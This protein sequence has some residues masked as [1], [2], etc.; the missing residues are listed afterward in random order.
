MIFQVVSPQVASFRFKP[1]TNHRKAHSARTRKAADVA[2]PGKSTLKPERS[3]HTSKA[4]TPPID[5]ALVA[6]QAS[7]TELNTGPFSA[8]LATFT[9]K[10][11]FVITSDDE[12]DIIARVAITSLKKRGKRS[13]ER[14]AAAKQEISDLRLETRVTWSFDLTNGT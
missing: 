5:P 7:R 11:T 8:F 1:H 14:L 6:I 2:L 3:S 4:P 12:D 10:T 13:K 9:P